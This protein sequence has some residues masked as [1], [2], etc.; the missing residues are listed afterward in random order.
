MLVLFHIINE[1][2]MHDSVPRLRESRKEREM[3][4]KEGN[5]NKNIKWKN[6]NK[7]K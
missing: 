4:D 2:I 1:L 3:D 5:G 7:D 6:G